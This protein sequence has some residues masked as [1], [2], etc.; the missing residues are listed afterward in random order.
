MTLSR[1]F[2]VPLL[3]SRD[4]SRPVAT[5]AGPPGHAG[6]GEERLRP[7]TLRFETEA[8][9]RAWCRHD[10]QASLGRIRLTLGLALALYAVF[11]WLDLAI[12]PEVAREIGWIRVVVCTWITGVLVAT[13]QPGFGRWRSALLS[14]TIL[15]TGG[16]I[17]G[18]LALT[19]G[20]VE[21]LYYVG[22]ILVLMA[23]HAFRWLPFPLALVTS[24]AVVVG[25]DVQLA[26]QGGVEPPVILNNHFFFLS[27]LLLGA[28][29]SYSSE[30]SARMSFLH[31]LRAEDER[32]RNEALL[33]N[34]LPEPVAQR[35]KHQ[36]GPVAERFEEVSVLFLDLV[37]FSAHSATVAPETLVAELNTLFS[38]L[39]E[40]A[41]AHGVEKIKT[42][43]DA[44]LAVAGLPVAQPDHAERMAAMALA[45]RDH[46]AR[47]SPHGPLPN[48]VR[49]GIACGPV[50][51][52]VIGRSK[53]TYDLW[54]EPVTM[55]SRMQVHG[56]PG[57]IQVTDAFR[58]R[59]EHAYEFE[60]RGAIDV[61][62]RGPTATWW[63]VGRRP[64]RAR[65][66]SRVGSGQPEWEEPVMGC[67]REGFG[68][69]HPAA[70]VVDWAPH[71]AATGATATERDR[72]A[73]RGLVDRAPVISRSTASRVGGLL[74]PEALP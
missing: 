5:A 2:A 71:Y 36:P 56:L 67:A 14:L 42:M 29:A 15:A 20:G 6:L 12:A 24:L 62:G 72:P 47:R 10:D 64:S 73:G 41:R 31:A 3:V 27:A 38:E 23:T 4:D 17:V 9:E 52:G 33:R 50:V 25:Y 46:F 28:V 21:S 61:K 74:C 16:G 39:D 40:I 58:R 54:G 66:R 13:R 48:R 45:C 63:L 18:M 22:L 1:P 44:Y 7:F 55:A 49:I 32:T 69:C 19:S 34:I 43:G 37:N 30:R 68:D 57:R 35:L 53:L 8:T 11:A 65:C 59:L 60:H 51:A 70:R 26:I